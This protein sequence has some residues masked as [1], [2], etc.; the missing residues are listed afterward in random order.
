MLYVMKTPVFV[1]VALCVLS[2][3]AFAHRIS[4]FAVVEEGVVKGSV[5]YSGGQA[6][7]G[8]PIQVLGPAGELLLALKTDDAGEFSFT[9]EQRCEHTIVCE[10]EDGHRA[11]YLL[12]A[13]ELPETLPLSGAAVPDS[14]SANAA[15]DEGIQNPGE[16]HGSPH[17]DTPAASSSPP[18]PPEIEAAVE[19]IVS[20]HVGDLRKELAEYEE[21]IRFHSVVGGLGFIL[22][23]MGLVF[24]FKARAR[25]KGPDDA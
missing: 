10:T 25:L 1:G 8:V 16:A 17:A 14:M 4:V 13:E 2:L 20:R 23:I 6:A 9:A 22:G 5:Y 15:G 7:H 24:Y 18:A 12:S 3:D 19:R 11:E 21:R